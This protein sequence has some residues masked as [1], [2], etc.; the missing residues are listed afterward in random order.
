MDASEIIRK[1]EKKLGQ[2][3]EVEE[4]ADFSQE[5]QRFRKEMAP[6]LTRYENLAKSFGSIIRIRPSHKDREKIQ[7]YIDTARL[8]ITP[9]DALSFAA[10]SFI[11]IFV[12]AI[13]I[14][15]LIIFLTSSIPFQFFLF[16]IIIDSFIFYYLYTKPKRIA[17]KYRL[18]AS[19]QMVQ[20][21]L[22]V[23]IYMKNASNLERAIAFAARNLQYPLGLDFKKIFWDVETGKF[24]TIKESLDAYLETWRDYSPEF[25]EAFHLVESSLYEPLEPRRIQ[26]LEKAL[27]VIL[28]GVYDKILRYSHDVKAPLT[29]LYMLGIILPTL[30]LALLPLAST[31]LGGLIKWYHIFILFN[32]LI[33]FLVFYL[34]TEITSKRPGGYGES[35]V[36]E[37]HPLYP[38]YKS[39][40]PYLLSFIIVLPIII[41]GILPFIFQFT[42]L[43]DYLGMLKDPSFSDLGLG[44]SDTKLF[45]FKITSTGT[46][47][48]FSQYALILSLFIP[49]GFALFFSIA[50]KMKTKEIIKSREE[51]KKLEDEFSSSLFQLGNRLGEGIPA[52]IVFSHVAE[53]TKGQ[54]T[55]SFFKTINTNI[56]QLGMSLED[57]IFNKQRGALIFFP[58][59]LIATSMKILIES[60]KK[61]LNIAAQSII[62]ISEYVKN[63]KRINERLRDLLA[64][65]ISDMKSNMNFL[66]PLLSGIVIGL[67]SMI[68]LILN[69]LQSAI[70]A[71]E[72]S[73][74]GIGNITN[75]ISIFNLEEMIPPYFLQ[76]AIG[77]YII[78][79]VFII[80]TTLVTIDA[81][82]DKLKRDYEMARNLK[83]SLYLYIITAAIS[84]ILL[85]LISSAVLGGLKL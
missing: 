17:N 69:Q 35:D 50:L 72:T 39:N 10:T 29:N 65:I 46:K 83:K 47:G 74:L 6:E 12:T 82:E 34:T 55:E 53:S 61:G 19:S 5:Y 42:P 37:L 76:I 73:A 58:S 15:A 38:Q 80:T 68:T 25:I 9:E 41:I 1:Y 85:G 48:P 14:S 60:V 79:I 78:Q 40:I 63:I 56:Q 20:A 24:S 30:G 27:N 84:I 2:N 67:A 28:D 81:G 70:G 23:V 57:S 51:N 75:I 49:L 33:P 11:L 26:I 62:A 18:K 52:E 16:A 21:V 64:E 45:D 59:N 4:P 3:V 8:E 43:P 54:V 32:L 66:A 22:Y 77:L 44:S 7:N 71:T 36:I 13:L 31:L